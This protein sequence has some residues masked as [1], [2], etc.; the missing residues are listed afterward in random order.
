MVFENGEE[1]NI[2]CEFLDIDAI[3]TSELSESS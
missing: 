1:I 3:L 2:A